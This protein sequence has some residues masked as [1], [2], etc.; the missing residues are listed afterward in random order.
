MS[1]RS[2][3]APRWSASAPVDSG[4]PATHHDTVD[5]I[6]LSFEIIPPR[7][8]NE[9]DV[10]ALDHLLAELAVYYPDYVCVTSSQRSGWLDGTAALIERI[11][12]TTRMR[13]VAHLA[14]TTGPAEE[15]TRGVNR[16]IDAGVRGILALRGDLPAGQ[17]RLPA[18]YLPYATDLV[19]VIRAVE[20][21]QAARFAAGSLAVGV[22]CYPLGH[23][24]SPTPEQDFD[25]LL[26]KQRLGATF[27]ITQ[28]FFDAGDYLSFVRKA[29][30]AGVTIPLIPGIMPMTSVARLE[31]MGRLAGIAVPERLR[32]TLSEAAEISPAAEHEAGLRATVDLARACLAGGAGGLHL[33]T[34]NDAELT[35]ELLARI[36]VMPGVSHY[37]ALAGVALPTAC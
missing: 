20:A 21:R 29:R 10:A 33:Y 17:D 14:C 16:L 25:V 28:L 13:P 3:A 36:G 24:E 1:F 12:A 32:R 35:H 2:Q 26:T 11:T 6:A 23:A 18:G 4:E 31:R 5:R 34:H 15:L 30:L 22:A 8:G 27:A 37:D 7:W 19:R 9:T